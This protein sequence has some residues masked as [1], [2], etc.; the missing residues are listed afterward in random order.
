M[1]S[2]VPSHD[3]A[4]LCFDADYSNDHIRQVHVFST[5]RRLPKNLARGEGL[6]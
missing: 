1:S 6:L 4:K 3:K 2:P 5:A